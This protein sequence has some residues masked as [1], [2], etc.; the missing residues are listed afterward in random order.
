MFT[1]TKGATVK[2]EEHARSL[3]AH[4]DVADSFRKKMTNY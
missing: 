4:A 3:G 2:E 1:T